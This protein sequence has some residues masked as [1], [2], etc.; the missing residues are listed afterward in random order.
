MAGAVGLSPEPARGRG[1]RRRRTQAAGR[2]SSSRTPRPSASKHG[3]V[4]HVTG[5][6][7]A[8]LLGPRYADAI[9]RGVEHVLASGRGSRSTRPAAASR[10]SRTRHHATS[11]TRRADGDAPSSPR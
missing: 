10:R 1:H 4:E 2:S 8:N 3:Y 7:H 11:A 9:V 6:N 5:A